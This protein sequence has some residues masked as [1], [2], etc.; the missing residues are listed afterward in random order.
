M[1]ASITFWFYHERVVM[2]A[3]HNVVWGNARKLHDHVNHLAKG[4]YTCRPIDGQW[5]IDHRWTG[6]APRII[7]Q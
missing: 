7:T 3:T 6:M 5:V 4:Y 1:T 2:T